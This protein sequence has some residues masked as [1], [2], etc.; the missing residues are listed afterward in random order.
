MTQEFKDRSGA[1]IAMGIFEILGGALL[2][3]FAVFILFSLQMAPEESPAVQII[4]PLLAYGALSAWFFVMGIGTIRAK[5]WARILMLAANWFSLVAG[6]IATAFFLTMFPDIF[7]Q[8]N[9]DEATATPMVTVT[10]IIFW[11]FYIALPLIGIFFYRERNVRATCEH[12]NPTP[13][14]TERCPLPVLTLSLLMFSGACSVLTQ[15]ATNYVHPFFG[16]LFAGKSGLILWIMNALLCGILGVG[17]YKQKLTAWCGTLVYYALFT[18]SNILT[19]SKI[20][21]DDFYAAANCSDDI[22]LQMQQSAWLNEAW[23]IKHCLLFFLPMTAYL[24][25]IKRYFKQPKPEECP[26]D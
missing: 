26:N 4:A 12:R 10:G 24:L 18:L 13:S 7:S 19:F 25:F 1:L 21:M 17:L 8:I 3:L 16:T 14:W 23:M 6:I 22:R 2:A 15:I 5:R 20:T 11:I 9:M